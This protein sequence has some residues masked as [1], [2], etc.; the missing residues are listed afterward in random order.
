MRTSKQQ[1]II[2]PK[3]AVKRSLKDRLRFDRWQLAALILLVVV[4]VSWTLIAM[5]NSTLSVT[6]RTLSIPG[7]PSALEGY[8]I[9][10]VS[11]LNGAR[12]GDNQEKL[13]KSITSINYDALCMTGD[14][15]GASG[16]AQ[17]LYELVDGINAQ[18]SKP[19]LFITGDADPDPIESASG[20]DGNVYADYINQLIARGVTYLDSP[21]EVEKGDA[22][23]WFTSAL[24]LNVNTSEYLDAAQQRCLNAMSQG[25]A[26]T[27]QMEA[28]RLDCAQKLNTAAQS[29]QSTDV[30]IALSHTPLSDDF[31]RS[32]QYAEGDLSAES[33]DSSRS[34]QYLRLIDVALCGHYVGGQWR[35]PFVGAMY[36]PDER[37]PRGGWFPD[38]SQVKGLRRSNS[39]YIYTTS[40]LGTSSAY[41]LPSFRLFNTPEIVVIKLTAK[42]DA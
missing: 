39:V 41:H 32:L 42:L 25:D 15:I 38:Q 4:T 37:L 26:D 11:D 18:K 5:G 1:T 34:N 31:V 36:V 28:Y 17:P 3:K 30:H 2:K 40:G 21:Y 6:T 9:V 24:H 27:A 29:M 8:T 23:V 33:Q 12:F 10:Q 14:M 7:L 22:R 19:M 35:V 20:D 13:V 16:D